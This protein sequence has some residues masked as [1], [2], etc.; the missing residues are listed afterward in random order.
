MKD[1]LKQLRE[2]RGWNQEQ[3]AERMH[4]SRETISRMESA[5]FP[6]EPSTKYLEEAARIFGIPKSVLL[7]AGD[8]SQEE[9]M[10]A[11]S[12][13]DPDAAE[14]L[15]FLKEYPE[16]R[17]AVARFI[18]D[19]LKGELEEEKGASGEREPG[20]SAATENTG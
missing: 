15:E 19:F 6:Q 9:E 8:I 13:A 16:K 5:S 7:L 12:A 3:M 11:L 18:R 14:V 17:K 10:A 2:E 20:R 1:L 4:R